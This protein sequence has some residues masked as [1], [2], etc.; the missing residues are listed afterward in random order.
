MNSSWTTCTDISAGK[1]TGT[2]TGWMNFC[3][4]I[5]GGAAPMITAW[6]A[7]QYGWRAAILATASAGIIGAI[8]WLF[9]KPDVPLRHRYSEAVI[10]V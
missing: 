5:I 6:I 3:G 2:I 7:T 10:S 9:V 1:F 8:F 4:N